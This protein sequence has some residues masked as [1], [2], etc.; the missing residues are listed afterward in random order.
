MKKI[1][2]LGTGVLL[3][4]VLIGVVFWNWNNSSN[5]TEIVQDQ[6]ENSELVGEILESDGNANGSG[7]EIVNQPKPQYKGQDLNFLASQDIL[8]LYPKELIDG[9]TDRLKTAVK[10][11]S[12]QPDSSPYWIEIGVIKKNFDNYIG[13]RDAW[14]YAKIIDS[15]NP[16]HYFN[17][18][19]LYAAYLKDIPKAEQNY[20][21]AVQLEPNNEYTHL[22]LADFYKDFYKEKSDQIDDVLLNGLSH[23]PKNPNLILNLAFYYRDSG[24]LALAIENIEKFLKVA[25]DT[26][27][28]GQHRESVEAELARLKSITTN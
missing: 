2:L 9:Q 24:R 7:M 22:G 15:N 21:M 11:L 5:S 6:S 10:W 23:L 27:V 16:I 4:G 1:L 13:V 17:L 14:E 20:L 12:D 26:D 8:N 3:A 18:G 19:N 28:T 25:N